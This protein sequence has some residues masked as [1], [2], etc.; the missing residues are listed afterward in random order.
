M[1]SNFYFECSYFYPFPR[2]LDSSAPSGRPTRPSTWQISQF[3]RRSTKSSG[4]DDLACGIAISTVYLHTHVPSCQCTRG[5]STQVVPKF[6]M[7]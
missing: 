6:M 1:K 4:Q 7:L 3:G 2:S 5:S